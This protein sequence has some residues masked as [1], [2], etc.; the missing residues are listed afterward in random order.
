MLYFRILTLCRLEGRQQRS[1]EE[2]VS[3][4]AS[5]LV[6]DNL[7]VYTRSKTQNNIV[8]CTKNS[9]LFR[10]VSYRSNVAHI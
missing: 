10:S 2:T 4:T 5:V 1:E 3:I 9:I 8:N 7:R 6:G